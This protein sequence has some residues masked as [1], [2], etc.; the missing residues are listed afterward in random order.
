MKDPTADRKG[1][2]W[3]PDT[4]DVRVAG[5]LTWR[6]NGNPRLDLIGTLTPGRRLDPDSLL[7]HG[8]ADGAQLTLADCREVSRRGLFTG[9]PTSE[10]L[11]GAAYQDVIFAAPDDIALNTYTCGIEH[12]RNWIRASG[13]EWGDAPEHS[14][15]D[16]PHTESVILRSLPRKR[17]TRPPLEV[18]ITHHVDAP[19]TAFAPLTLT[20]EFRLHVTSDDALPIERIEEVATDLQHLVGI[21]LDRPVGRYDEK[22]TND[23]YQTTW[24]VEGLERTHRTI[25]ILPTYRPETE[26]SEPEFI[27]PERMNFS[28]DDIGGIE[29][30]GAWL[31]IME[32]HRLAAYRVGSHRIRT[33][34]VPQDD[35]I[36]VVAAAEGIHRNSAPAKDPDGGSWTLSNRIRSLAHRCGAGFTE[37]ITVDDWVRLL[38]AERNDIAHHLAKRSARDWQILVPLAETVYYLCTMT[39]LEQM[40]QRGAIEKISK[41]SR[42]RHYADEVNS[43]LVGL[44]EHS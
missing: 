32:R 23:A 41:N 29:G 28:F 5:M 1:T 3:L 17:V 34:R 40:G 27:V 43:Y 15:S 12:M 44:G 21:G 36:N 42:F 26:A 4:P 31:D 18:A 24:D 14:A 10:Y 38:V 25:A 11:V 33:A 37:R 35:F 9:S 19:Y 13:I 30:L 16:A 7:I 6:P 39:L 2:F 22:G 20:D 8:N